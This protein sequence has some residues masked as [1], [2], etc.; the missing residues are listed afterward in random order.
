MLLLVLLGGTSILSPGFISKTVGKTI[1]E[2]NKIIK[3][4]SPPPP[5]P[6]ESM[7]QGV[8]PHEWETR[9]DPEWM[10]H[11]KY[12]GIPKEGLPVLSDKEI[13]TRNEKIIKSA[14]EHYNKV[15][16]AADFGRW[17]EKKK[18]YRST[19][20]KW[21]EAKRARERLKTPITQMENFSNE[22]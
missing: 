15:N 2:V 9:N 12:G 22:T 5:T 14:E 20:E 16:N 4:Q 19:P 6:P 1:G 21:D 8:T 18:G 7:P 13:A 11:L 10:R 17:D 3:S